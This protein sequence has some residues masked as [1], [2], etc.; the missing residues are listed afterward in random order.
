MD[1][2]ET[3]S[4][5]RGDKIGIIGFCYGSR[6]GSLAAWNISDLSASVVFYGVGID[7]SLGDGPSPL[8]QTCNIGCPVLELFGVEDTNPRPENVEKID[9]ALTKNGK[10]H[11]FHSYAGSGHGFHCETRD[12]FRPEAAASAWAKAIAWLNKYLK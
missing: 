5:V 4:F 6:V 8:E 7:S 9:P 2:I 10:V 1:H 3:Q 11:K 12:G